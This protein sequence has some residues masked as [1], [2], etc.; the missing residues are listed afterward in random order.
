MQPYERQTGG[1]HAPGFQNKEVNMWFSKPKSNQQ[2]LTIQ[3]KIEKLQH[4]FRYGLDTN[5]GVDSRDLSDV[6]TALRKLST[7]AANSQAQAFLDY[8]EQNKLKVLIGYD[9]ETETVAHPE[10]LQE[11]LKRARR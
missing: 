9:G 7:E 11:Y 3:Q 2:K 6:V 4:L 1:N 10:L 8:N 5:T